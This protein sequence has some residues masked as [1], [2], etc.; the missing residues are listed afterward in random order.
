MLFTM[1]WSTFCQSIKSLLC[2]EKIKCSYFVH[3]LRRYISKIV[4][5]CLQVTRWESFLAKTFLSWKFIFSRKDS[6][7][8]LLGSYE[9]ARA[10][11]VQLCIGMIEQ[12]YNFMLSREVFAPFSYLGIL[13]LTKSLTEV[14]LKSLDKFYYIL[15]TYFGH[16][17]LLEY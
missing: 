13:L 9:F 8:K 14:T 11:H 5:R 3:L 16:C 1:S 10:I 17:K 6:S 15:H 4:V 12:V 2:I 7:E